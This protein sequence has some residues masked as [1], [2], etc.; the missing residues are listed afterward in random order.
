MSGQ[1]LVFVSYARADSEPVRAIVRELQALGVQTWVDAQN[2]SAGDV[3]ADSINNALQRANAVLIFISP[4]SVKSRWTLAELR[5]AASN[6]VKII[7]VM[8]RPTPFDELPHFLGK[9]Q[10][11]SVS[12]FPAELAPRLVAMEIARALSSDPKPALGEQLNT[13]QKQDLANALAAQSRSVSTVAEEVEKSAAPT[14]VFIVHGH[15]DAFLQDVVSFVRELRVTPIVMR[16]AG[17]SSTSLIEK[18][19][20]VG[21]AARYAIVLLSGDDFGV[22]R[23]QYEA[24]EGGEKATQFRARQN[25]VLELGYFY[26]LLGWENVF[27]LERA[28][29]KVFPNFERP[30]DLNGVLFDRYDQSGK[31]RT[32]LHRRLITHGFELPALRE[33]Q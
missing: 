26:G 6:N 11:V 25:V 14:S 13:A 21:G 23:V 29:P 5:H 7:P 15:D 30:S 20:D 18:F 28:P 9:L 3:W 22:S 33:T 24:A 31:W 16:D 1:P 8:L 10:H 19:F 12:N 4:E 27:V 2:L 17:G 32:E